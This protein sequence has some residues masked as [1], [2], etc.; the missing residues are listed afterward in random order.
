MKITVFFADCRLVFM[1]SLAEK[2]RKEK[3][4]RVDMAGENSLSVLDHVIR[5]SPD[6][7]IY[8]TDVNGEKNGFPL[9]REIRKACGDRVHV[10]A[11]S[12]REDI[13]TCLA[14]FSLGGS[15]YML[16]VAA[17]EEI[18]PA[19]RTVSRDCLFLSCRLQNALL[20]KILAVSPPLAPE[21]FACLS[22]GERKVLSRIQKGH[23]ISEI[24]DHFSLSPDTIDNSKKSIMRKFGIHSQTELRIRTLFSDLD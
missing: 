10:I 18:V 13:G 9:L 19:V 14:F 11:I 12:D 1:K 15:G 6:I 23:A 22:P 24:A 3:Y 16:R 21:Y 4:L 7:F 8:D 5:H 17:E 2:L 20:K